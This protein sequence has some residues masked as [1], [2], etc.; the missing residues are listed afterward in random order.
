M[1]G[2]KPPPLHTDSVRKIY[3]YWDVGSARLLAFPTDAAR[4]RR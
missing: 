4:R 1:R 2:K 3:S